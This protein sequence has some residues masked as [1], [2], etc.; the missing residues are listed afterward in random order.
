MMA[1]PKVRFMAVDM[2]GTFVMPLKQFATLRHL[3]RKLLPNDYHRVT[4]RKLSKMFGKPIR[5]LYDLGRVIEERKLRWDSFN[6]YNAGWWGPTVDVKVVRLDAQQTLVVVG[7]HQGGDVRSNYIY[8][9]FLVNR[10]FIDVSPWIDI[11]SSIAL[12]AEIKVDGREF[13]AITYDVEPWYDIAS[14]E[15]IP[16]TKENKELFRRLILAN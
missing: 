15:I 6:T 3:P 16:D 14:W 2:D 4:L 12:V 9:Y 13:T 8:H 7:V 10:P 5:S 11:F 1:K